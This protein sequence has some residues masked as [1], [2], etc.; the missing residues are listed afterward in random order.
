MK[1]IFCLNFI[2]LAQL[3]FSQKTYSCETKIDEVLLDIEKHEEEEGRALIDNNFQSFKEIK[4][5]LLSEETFDEGVELFVIY[6]EKNSRLSSLKEEVDFKKLSKDDMLLILAVDQA[7][8]SSFIAKTNKKYRTVLLRLLQKEKD[9]YL[10]LRPEGCTSLLFLTS[11][12]FTIISNAT[13]VYNFFH[14][15]VGHLLLGG[16][17]VS[18][19]ISRYKLEYP[20]D[21]YTVYGFEQYL[22]FKSKP[23]VS[24]FFT[25]LFAFGH[26]GL[27][28]FA[29]PRLNSEGYNNLAE[30]WG[31]D[32][33]DAWV[34]LSGSLPNY[35]LNTIGITSSI[36]LRHA[37]FDKLS[38]FF[39]LHHF[40]N[41]CMA[42][43]YSYSVIG[44]DSNSINDISEKTGH[45][46]ADWASLIAKNRELS[47]K[48]VTGFTAAA[49]T[50]VL[51][52]LFL[53]HQYYSASL[54][55]EYRKSHLI[56]DYLLSNLDKNQT[57]L[58]DQYLKNIPEK[59]KENLL[60]A[61]T[62]HQA[63]STEG[64]YNKKQNRA[65]ERKLKSNL[66]D[67]FEFMKKNITS[68]KSNSKLK[69]HAIKKYTLRTNDTLNSIERILNYPLTLMFI[70]SLSKAYG[71]ALNEKSL[72]QLGTAAQSLVPI[73]GSIYT[74]NHFFY[75]HQSFEK[76][77]KNEL[78][79]SALELSSCLS[80]FICTILVGF[81]EN[82]GQIED[83]CYKNLSLGVMLSQFS[84]NMLY[85]YKA[86]SYYSRQI[87]K[88]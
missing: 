29:R 32:D 6:I 70:A 14:E 34:S 9:L 18:K 11:L 46:F 75:F 71:T 56:V 86:I 1:K 74:F 5:K 20:S 30:S 40:F 60:K 22:D 23:T 37:K 8:S 88:A 59:Q 31:E 80:F 77:T 79:Y 68:E 24:H 83:L 55:C 35:F 2:F 25:W 78:I 48:Q 47:P 36:Y 28:G 42:I 17:L 54:D 49:F 33:S 39:F 53:S 3:F 73:A 43:D 26:K 27:L 62:L 72:S 63:V 82:E 58:L 44:Q 64:I 38:I 21:Y 66:T 45:D 10:D 84:T 13:G 16:G 4:E 67:F 19:P 69:A 50:F 7:L 12:L 81:Y 85:H 61:L 87:N 76:F 65:L 52:T 51:P 57:D 15:Y 41:F